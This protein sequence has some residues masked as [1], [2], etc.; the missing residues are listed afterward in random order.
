[1]IAFLLKVSHI[2]LGR[3]ARDPLPVAAHVLVCMGA[4]CI[5]DFC[6]SLQLARPLPVL[7]DRFSV[8]PPVT[9]FS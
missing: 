7:A 4:S 9:T 2:T 3:K 6:P 8:A 1:V 5:S